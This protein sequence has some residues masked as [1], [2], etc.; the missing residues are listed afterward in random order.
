MISMAVEE[1]K[2]LVKELEETKRKI[3]TSSK[4]LTELKRKHSAFW[5]QF[6]QECAK[7]LHDLT[8]DQIDCYEQENAAIEAWYSRERYRDYST[9]QEMW[10]YRPRTS[11]LY[12]KI[13]SGYDCPYCMGRV[14]PKRP[15]WGCEEWG[16]YVR[17]YFQAWLR[18]NTDCWPPEKK[19]LF[20]D[21]RK[22]VEEY[23]AKAEP[24]EQS[25]A[26]LYK[27]QKE[28][29][30]QLEEI[31]ELCDRTL[32]KGKERAKE[33]ARME[34]ELDE[35]LGIPSRDDVYWPD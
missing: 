22:E 24:L 32:G 31:W 5:T 15:S 17:D 19:A 18:Q 9:M 20:E 16:G 10:K 13:S 34:R 35:A 23:F 25:L 6:Q 33:K 3:S 28:I 7:T 14:G 2:K 21:A 27:K 29:W 4:K 8:Q 30:N 26:D 11:A 12:V 1:I